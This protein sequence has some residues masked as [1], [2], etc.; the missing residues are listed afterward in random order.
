M[1]S[2]FSVLELFFFGPDLLRSRPPKCLDLPWSEPSSLA[3]SLVQTSP[4]VNLPHV[5]LSS[6][7]ALLISLCSLGFPLSFDPDNSLWKTPFGANPVLP[8][9][10]CGNT[11]SRDLLKHVI[12]PPHVLQ[13][14]PVS[15]RISSL[16]IWTSPCP[17]GPSRV[18]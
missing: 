1:I 5:H 4:G 12:G 10:T 18:L 17:S 6:F 2:P 16:L 14:L 15:S 11:I 3:S 7:Y 8:L 9:R 13:D